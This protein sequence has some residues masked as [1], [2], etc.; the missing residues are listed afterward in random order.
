MKILFEKAVLGLLVSIG[1]MGAF[2]VSKSEGIDKP[3]EISKL[4]KRHQP[5][6][7]GV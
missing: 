7:N 1:L 4:S 3:K 2:G 6:A 5:Y